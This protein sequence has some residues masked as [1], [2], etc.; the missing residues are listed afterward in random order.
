MAHESQVR[1]RLSQVE[2]RLGPA[3]ALRYRPGASRAFFVVPAEAHR[4][5][6]YERA[7]RLARHP[8]WSEH[9]RLYGAEGPE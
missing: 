2:E 6:L 4:E 7:V 3:I 8:C 9:F 1:D 5:T